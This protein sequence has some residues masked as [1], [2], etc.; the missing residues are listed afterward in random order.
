[1]EILTPASAEETAGIERAYGRAQPLPLAKVTRANLNQTWLASQAQTKQAAIE[2]NNQSKLFG[3]SAD[4]IPDDPDLKRDMVDSFNARIGISPMWKEIATKYPAFSRAVSDPTKF[5]AAKDKLDRLAGIEHLYASM[6]MAR[7]A[8][9]LQD[10]IDKISIDLQGKYLNPYSDARISKIEGGSGLTDLEDR[11]KKLLLEQRQ[12]IPNDYNIAFETSR[13]GHFLKGLAEY[14][15]TGYANQL[16]A[17][18]AQVVQPAMGVHPVLGMAIAGGVMGIGGAVGSYSFFKDQAATQGITSLIE[19]GIPLTQEN[20][21]RNQVV[22]MALGAIQEIGGG[23]IAKL[24][25]KTAGAVT[26]K[27]LPDISKALSENALLKPIADRFMATPSKFVGKSLSQAVGEAVKDVVSVNL[28]MAGENYAQNFAVNLSTNKAAHDA[29]LLSLVKP[30]DQIMRESTAGLGTGAITALPLTL[31]M[32]SLGVA[33]RYGGRD[34]SIEKLSGDEKD[35]VI[36]DEIDKQVKALDMR[37]STPEIADNLHKSIATEHG[38]THIGIDIKDATEQIEKAGLDPQ[39]VFNQSGLGVFYQ[40]ALEKNLDFIEVPIE[41]MHSVHTSPV[42]E[43]GTFT[44]VVQGAYRVHDEGLTRNQV[45]QVHEHAKEMA[46][47]IELF[48]E[49]QPD[50]YDRV[51]KMALAVV[52]QAYMGGKKPMRQLKQEAEAASDII[53]RLIIRNSQMTGRSVEDSVNALFPLIYGPTDL[54]RMTPAKIKADAMALARAAIKEDFGYRINE[55][56]RVSGRSLYIPAENWADWQSVIDQYPKGMFTKDKKKGSNYWEILSEMMPELG[57]AIDENDAM[58]M[59]DRAKYKSKK[60]ADYYL[61]DFMRDQMEMISQIPS[62][63]GNVYGALG[64]TNTKSYP[65][66][67]AL[68]KNFDSTTLLHELGH[69]YITDALEFYRSTESTPEHKAAFDPIMQWLEI[70]DDQTELNSKQQE[71]FAHSFEAYLKSATA[72]SSALRRTFAQIRK[73]MVDVYRTLKTAAVQN[74]IMQQFLPANAERQ[75]FIDAG[76][77]IDDQLG[78]SINPEVR[79]YF[80][81]MLAT[82]E[83][84]TAVKQ[85][86]GSNRAIQEKLGKLGLRKDLLDKLAKLHERGEDAAFIELWNAQLPELQSN[87]HKRRDDIIRHQSDENL[88]G[89]V[90]DRM[91]NDSDYYY[92][93]IWADSE[94]GIDGKKRS[95]MSRVDAFEQIK[96]TVMRIRSGELPMDALMGADSFLLVGSLEEAVSRLEA[97]KPPRQHLNELVNAYADKHLPKLM[98]SEEF[99]QHGIMAYLSTENDTALMAELVAMSKVKKDQPIDE[100]NAAIPDRDFKFLKSNLH[101]LRAAAQEAIGKLT[102]PELRKATRT[103]ITQERRYAVLVERWMFKKLERAQEFQK[104]RILSGMKLREAIRLN[105]AAEKNRETLRQAQLFNLNQMKN[106]YHLDALIDLLKRFNLGQKHANRRSDTTLES[107]ANENIGQ[108][109]EW[110]RRDPGAYIS[111]EEWMR[112]ESDP[113]LGQVEIARWIIDM[114]KPMIVDDLTASQL[115]DVA[116]AI[117]NIKQRASREAGKHSAELKEKLHGFMRSILDFA[118]EQD[119]QDEPIKTGT[120]LVMEKKKFIYPFKQIGY[121]FLAHTLSIEHMIVSLAPHVEVVKNNIHQLLFQPF[122]DAYTD[123][124]LEYAAMSERLS[125]IFKRIPIKEWQ[126]EYV[127]ISHRTGFKI[128]MMDLFGAA[129]HMGSESNL[130]RLVNGWRRY[131]KK[132]TAEQIEMIMSEK[133]PDQAWDVVQDIW[134]EVN[135]LWPRI[136]SRYKELYGFAPVKVEG[137]IFKM[138]NR[139]IQGGYMPLMVAEGYSRKVP[140]TELEKFEMEGSTY[141]STFPANRFA[142]ERQAGGTSYLVET[143]IDAIQK[144]INMVIRDLHYRHIMID[145]L[146]ILKDQDFQRIWKSNFGEQ[147]MKSLNDWLLY[148]GNDGLKP[149]A[150]FP[151]LFDPLIRAATFGTMGWNLKNAIQDVVTSP[152]TTFHKLGFKRSVKVFKHMP[153]VARALAKHSFDDMP[154]S[155]KR[156]FVTDKADFAQTIGKHQQDHMRDPEMWNNVINE[157]KNQSDWMKLRFETKYTDLYDIVYDRQSQMNEFQKSMLFGVFHWAQALTEIPIWKESYDRSRASGNSKSES[158]KIADSNIAMLFG[159]GRL[160]DRPNLLQ[161]KHGFQRALNMFT[162]WI[163]AQSGNLYLSARRFQTGTSREKA[164]AIAYVVS[165]TMLMP[166]TSA[167]IAGKRPEDDE[168]WLQFGVKESIGFSSRM[169]PMLNYFAQPIAN[170]AAGTWDPSAKPMFTNAFGILEQSLNATNKTFSDSIDPHEKIEAWT[171]VLPYIPGV[172][173]VSEANTLIWNTYDAVRGELNF[174]PSRDFFSRRPKKK[175]ENEGE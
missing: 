137:R 47:E 107:W 152:F 134:A 154:E 65:K 151:E 124:K 119:M 86:L 12:Y 18:G 32:A 63:K 95:K 38:V 16:A 91:W 149:G 69:V 99:H 144:H 148:I 75:H 89:S 164:M 5:S 136:E 24:V 1:M 49:Q 166:I 19:N 79:G 127:T 33:G 13:M 133:L 114:Q 50:E 135:S 140:V 100:V 112:S 43:H 23:V 45:Q 44:D 109:K 145:A 77:L 165:L 58:A 110:P 96:D 83:E 157:V 98:D 93:K 85:A 97:L 36:F 117:K 41:Q 64:A 108:P 90:A 66:I 126:K 53:A 56:R 25:G 167:L 113:N 2:K 116:N 168:S 76:W 106:Q 51:K 103:F 153:A 71:T 70:T 6:S 68:F 48:K 82:D 81:R 115:M 60:D 62:Q 162:T 94:K 22:S 132:I 141:L 84:I 172:P 175:R 147:G 35:S 54:K 78:I 74:R 73:W 39:V 123:Y 171:K 101:V 29:G 26:A 17:G 156:L 52:T 121:S 4:I 37:D 88:T 102:L 170:L 14:V 27:A 122:R 111:F 59:F 42:S 118:F 142:Q 146:Y 105:R 21:T 125:G 46:Q 128:T 138:G 155:M 161:Q 159:S 92:V 174:D 55:W 40:E 173:W 163:Y 80:D 11:L 150:I 158:M 10:E 120:A 61:N 28:V 87:Y 15:T 8:N 3:I 67:I 57:G 31:L 104:L 30:L 9:R 131:D 139:E 34:Y 143:N 72:P 130:E 160:E 7:K 20:M 169:V 129:L